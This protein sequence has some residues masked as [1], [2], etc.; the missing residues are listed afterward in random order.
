MHVCQNE[1]TMSQDGFMKPC[2]A[3]DCTLVDDSSSV[4]AKI[5]TKATEVLLELVL[6][7]VPAEEVEDKEGFMHRLLS[8]PCSVRLII[9][10]SNA[11]NKN[12]NVRKFGSHQ[13]V[14]FT[15]GNSANFKASVYNIIE[16]NVCLHVFSFTRIFSMCCFPERNQVSGTFFTFLVIMHWSEA[17]IAC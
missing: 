16:C 12:P 6:Q 1:K 17:V 2:F 13:V 11:T 14:A 10:H 15:R 7:S 9:S 4:A 5:F 8:R 3:L